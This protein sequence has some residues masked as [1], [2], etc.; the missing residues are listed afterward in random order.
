MS[1]G[2]IRELSSRWE[3]IYKLVCSYYIVDYEAHDHHVNVSESLCEYLDVMLG[4]DSDDQ[5][6]TCDEP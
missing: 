4:P 3:V 1:V 2:G 5:S 6:E